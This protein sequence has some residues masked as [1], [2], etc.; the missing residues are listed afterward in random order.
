[1]GMIGKLV[2]LTLRTVWFVCI[3]WW[4]GLIYIVPALL[5]SPFWTIYGGNGSMLKKWWTITTLKPT[6]KS[7]WN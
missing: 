5:M 3:G 7:D 1:M 2:R 6:K 4:L